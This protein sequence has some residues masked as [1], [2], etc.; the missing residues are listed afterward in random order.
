MSYADRPF[1]WTFQFD[2]AHVDGGAGLADNYDLAAIIIP[3]GVEIEIQRFSG[4]VTA[5]DADGEIELCLED[6]TVISELKLDATGHVSGVNAGT[7]TATTFPYRVAP[8]SA[9][10]PK[11]LKLRASAALDAAT[12]AFVNV[13]ITGLCN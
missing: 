12:G 9:T 13:L 8:Q 11:L 10:L 2:T 3:A 4:Y 6:N 1:L 7:T 5:A